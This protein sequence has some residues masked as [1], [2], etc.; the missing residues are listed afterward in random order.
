MKKLIFNLFAI[1]L[2]FAFSACGS[3]DEK[4]EKFFTGDCKQTILLK[5]GA[6]GATITIP[7]TST[8]DDMLKNSSGYGSPV[9]SGELIIAGSNTSINVTGLPTGVALKDF[10]LNINGIEQSFG[11]ISNEKANLNLYTSAYSDYF[12]RTFNQMVANKKL[13]VKVTFV[14]TVET[15]N[16]V[17]LEIVF[18]GRFSYWVKL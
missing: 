10:K 7:A 16:N 2:L 8:L 4:E 6:A 1:S 17:K 12:N 3:D 14:P 5:S 13:D 11:E 9:S 15:D 18:S